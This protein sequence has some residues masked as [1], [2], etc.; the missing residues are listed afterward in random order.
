MTV[1]KFPRKPI[2]SFK[3]IVNPRIVASIWQIRESLVVSVAR[4]VWKKDICRYQ[5]TNLLF[6][7][8]IMPAMRVLQQA[9][10]L[11]DQL[12]EDYPTHIHKGKKVPVYNSVRNQKL[13]KYLAAHNMIPLD[14][15][16]PPRPISVLEASE[17]LDAQMRESVTNSKG[18]QNSICTPEI[19]LNMLRENMDVSYKDSDWEDY[20]DDPRE[21]EPT[22]QSEKDPEQV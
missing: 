6:A 7:E 16:T 2:F 12:Y 11:V 20:A 18:E 14:T 3:S 1:K 19:R 8:D 5:P 17:S 22:N 9:L 15:E 13:R 10:D 21:D 4:F